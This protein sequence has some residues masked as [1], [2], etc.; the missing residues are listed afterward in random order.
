MISSE[1]SSELSRYECNWKD[2]SNKIT[3]H[4][5][6]LKNLKLVKIDMEALDDFQSI[7]DAHNKGRNVSTS[8]AIP[9]NLMDSK[10]KRTVAILAPVIIAIF[11]LILGLSCWCVRR[12]YRYRRYESLYFKAMDSISPWK[13]KKSLEEPE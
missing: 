13:Q 4:P 12:L 5:K 2:T 8:T 9:E 1:S 7:F 10:T 6:N 3:W 11:I